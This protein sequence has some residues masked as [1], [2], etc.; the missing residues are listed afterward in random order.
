M[1]LPVISAFALP[2]CSIRFRASRAPVG[3]LLC[4]SDS[5]VVRCA[6]FTV[7]QTM[8]FTVA[9]GFRWMISLPVSM[10][11]VR[12]TFVLTGGEPLA[13]PNCRALLVRLC[14]SGYEVSLET[15]GAL[16]I[17]NIDPRVTVV[18]DIKTP[19]SGESARNRL[20][21]LPLLRAEDQLKF[22]ICNRADYQWSCEFVRTHDL[23]NSC[24]VLFSPAQGSLEPKDL[25]EWIL[26]DRLPVR[27]QVQLHKYLWGDAPGH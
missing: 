5:P 19:A 22:V 17:A 7:I 24:C 4:S 3:F 25:A 27:F 2:R 10:T 16:D 6:V 23:L 8:H 18:M 26:A 20:E 13:Q 21:N 9:T 14:D 12:V 11:L 15:A 1:R